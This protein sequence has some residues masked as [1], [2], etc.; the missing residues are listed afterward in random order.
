LLKKENSFHFSKAENSSQMSVIQMDFP[1]WPPPP[2][3]SKQST[4]LSSKKQNTSQKI[5]CT[6]FSGVET[7]YV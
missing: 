2:H 3:F 1:M 4:K 6:F 7:A 5:T